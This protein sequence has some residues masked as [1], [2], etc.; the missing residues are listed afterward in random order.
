LVH[1]K[2]LTKTLLLVL[3]CGFLPLV[4]QSQVPSCAEALNT[5]VV[6]FDDAA[7]RVFVRGQVTEIATSR[8]AQSFFRPLQQIVQTCRPSWRK[9]WSMSVFSESTYAGYK[10]EPQLQELV[11]DGR[12]G[13]A[14]VGEYDRA[15]QKLILN[16][17]NPK[18]KKWLRVILP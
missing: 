8:K 6:K 17:E 2:K 15:S 14:Y 9:G 1:G 11:R 10:D 4:C 3:L 12:W 16:P 13:R 5:R 18:E 7:K